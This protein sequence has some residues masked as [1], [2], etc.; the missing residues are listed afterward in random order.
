MSHVPSRSVADSFATILQWL[1]RAVASQG[2]LGRL[3]APIVGL[4][5]GR[6][7]AAG[8][9]FARLAA[10]LRAGSFVPRRY[11]PRRK[12][13]A[14]KPRRPAALPRNFGWL[15]R[16]V[17][18]A[19]G[20]RSQLDHLLRE[21]EMAALLAA[22]PAPMARVLR[23][24]CWALL[25]KPP[26]VLARPRRPPPPDPEP[27]ALAPAPS[28]AEPSSAPRPHPR[29]IRHTSPARGRPARKPPPR[30]CGP[31]HPA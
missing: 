27:P 6:I 15:L 2:I 18:E 13:A 3:S 22:A 24:L 4:L 1:G 23:P 9:D 10:R 28:A 19:V 31:P 30:A 21:P 12:P 14:R 16:M 26:P 29:G 8:R 20:F 5:L 7:A 25:L 11:S 17:P